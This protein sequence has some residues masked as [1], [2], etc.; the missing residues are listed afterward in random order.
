MYGSLTGIC[1]K[2][3]QVSECLEVNQSAFIL[4]SFSRIGLCLLGPRRSVMIT[5]LHFLSLCFSHVLCQ[6]STCLHLFIKPFFQQTLHFSFTLLCSPGKIKALSHSC[7]LYAGCVGEILHDACL[8][9]VSL[10]HSVTFF[11]NV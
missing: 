11:D 6:H 9:V 7:P 2:L 5:I 1:G 8:H 4:L 3:E 10:M